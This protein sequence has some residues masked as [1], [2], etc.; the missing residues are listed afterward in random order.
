[1]YIIRYKSYSNK[2]YKINIKYNCRNISNRYISGFVLD[3]YCNCMPN[4]F[5]TL[6]N[7]FTND[8]KICKTDKN[9][10]FKFNVGR[11]K[12]IY[13]IYA[14]YNNKNSNKITINTEKIF[15][16]INLIINKINSNFIISGNVKD[17]NNN[18]IEFCTVNLYKTICN[19]YNL[20]YKSKTNKYG[21]FLLSNLECGN[22]TIIIYKSGYFS[23]KYTLNLVHFNKINTLNV[24]LKLKDNGSIVY[25][26]ITDICNNAVSYAD[27]VLYKFNYKNEL[28]PIDFT[29]TNKN[30]FYVFH[31]VENGK[32][33]IKSNKIKCVNY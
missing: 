29:K 7:K 6:I 10:Y 15:N 11:L 8:I 5:V 20:I 30:G 24:R 32:Y 21:D 25:G 18:N 2:I 28:V 9:G 12:H 22:Y 14:S 31:K 16:K 27:V 1:M 13:Y 26:L 19:S 4:A 3:N 17:I 33:L 23:E